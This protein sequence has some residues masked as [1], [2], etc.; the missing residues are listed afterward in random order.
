MRIR[1][2]SATT[3][4]VR[5]FSSTDAVVNAI[6]KGVLCQLVSRTIDDGQNTYFRSIPWKFRTPLTP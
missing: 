5:Q 4:Y 1:A 6:P 2:A 3:M